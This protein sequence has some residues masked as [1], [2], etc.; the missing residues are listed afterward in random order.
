MLCFIFFFA[1]AGSVFRPR[2]FLVCACNTVILFYLC[3]IV[4][5]ITVFKITINR[6]PRNFMT[7]K[8]KLHSCDNGKSCLS[9]M[10]K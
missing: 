10:P 1:G 8:K 2:F 9:S 7:G 4:T 5:S 6:E 3:V